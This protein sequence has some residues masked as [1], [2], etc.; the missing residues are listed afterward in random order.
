[1]EKIRLNKN[2]RIYDVEITLLSPRIQLIFSD[3]IPSI[4]A[5]SEGFFIL[6]E[7]SGEA[8]ADYRAYKYEYLRDYSKVILTTSESDKYS[9][10]DDNDNN[11]SDIP[12]PE[13]DPVDLNE[14]LNNLK[15]EKILMLSAACEDAIMK[16]ISIGSKQY[17][18]TLQDQS[19][20]QNALQIAK[21]TGLYV[22]YHNDNESCSLYSLEEIAEI[23]M[24][25][26]CNITKNQTY[27]N[28]MKLYIESIT[29]TNMISTVRN[30]IWGTPLIG[31]YL[32]TYNAIVEQSR[33]IAQKFAS[34]SE[35]SNT[36]D[37]GD[38][39]SDSESNGTSN[40]NDIEVDSN[41]ATEE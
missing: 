41:A 25:Q 20:L 12:S 10:S 22:P 1:M 23:Y 3:D 7:H 30:I 2:K 24:Y 31:V 13:P 37:S 11:G 18:Y 32:E 15:E 39:E 26:Q 14:V 35:K 5:L 4:E 6:N 34:S 16:G 38:S 33:L 17:S 27:F 28:Q 21:E 36:E 8:Q 19:N 29:D 9:D 40:S